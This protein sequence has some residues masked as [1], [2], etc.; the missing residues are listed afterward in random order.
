MRD[1]RTF[2]LDAFD[3]DYTA[4]EHSYVEKRTW[5]LE[6]LRFHDT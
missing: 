5:K 1:A 6:K 4:S 3:V 2:T